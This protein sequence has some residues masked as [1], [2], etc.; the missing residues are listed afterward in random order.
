MAYL[1]IAQK[2]YDDKRYA[3]WYNVGPEECDCV[4]T[5]DLADLFV[6]S[7]GNGIRWVSLVGE[8]GPHEA[9]FLKLDCSRIKHVFGWRPIWH[10]E[11]AIRQTCEWTKVW[12]RGGDVLAETDREIAAFV[13]AQQ[14][15]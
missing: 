7:W 4:T 3:G 13:N 2:Q 15:A 12:Q 5:G 11:N 8:K 1:M 14:R 10:I 9:N 6:A